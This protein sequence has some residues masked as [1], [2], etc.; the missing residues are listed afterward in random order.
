MGG[1]IMRK[2]KKLSTLASILI[3]ASFILP[4]YAIISSLTAAAPTS[5]SFGSAGGAPG[6]TITVTV[7]AN[8]LLT[9][10]GYNITFTYD[11]TVLT[12]N[13]TGTVN[14]EVAGTFV[15][16]VGTA[17]TVALALAGTEGSTKDAP[18][19]L[20][21]VAFTVLQTA[22]KNSALTL[23]VV[24]LKDQD[25]ATIPGVAKTNGT[26]QLS[27]IPT[28]AITMT[29]NPTSIVADGTA[30]TTITS[31]AIKDAGGA[32]VPDGT[33]V[34]VAT[35]QGT[36]VATDADSVTAGTQVATTAGV[37]TFGLTSNLVVGSATVTANTVAGDATGTLQVPFTAVQA[38]KLEVTQITNPV[39]AGT[40]SNVQVKAVNAAGVTA[41]GYTGTVHFTST[42]ANATL[43]ANYT[44]LAGDNGVKV[45]TGGV[46]LKTKGTQN[47]T[48][49][50]TTTAT[51]TGSQT[52]IV[53]NAGAAAK[54]NLTV[55]PATLMVSSVISEATLTATILD[56]NN[57]VVTSFTD[58]VTF[59]VMGATAAFG[60][61]KATFTS[62]NA[63]AGVATSY[64]QSA[65][66]LTGGTIAC[67][68][69]ATGLTQGTV[70]VITI[71]RTLVSIAISIVTGGKV[72]T[73]TPKVGE[74][75]QF[76]AIGTYD[77]TT[78][79]DI[80]ATV[81][82]ASSDLTK[83]DF[84]A[85][86]GRFFAKAVGATNVTATK[87]GKTST[88]VAM[89]VQAATA[90][91][92]NTT[93]LPTQTTFGGTV[94]LGAAGVVA[95][96]TGDGFNYTI[97][98]GPTGGT[99]SAA[100]LFTAGANAGVYVLKVEDKSS[101]A[102]ATY[103]VVVPIT[104]TPSSK[105]I[106]RNVPQAFIVNGAGT[107]YTWDVLDSMTSTTP[108]TTYGAW[109]KPNPVTDDNTNTFTPLATLAQV[110]TFYVQVT[111]AGDADLTA[112]NGLNKK[113]FG[114]FRIIPVA[115][116]TVNVKKSDGTALSGALVKVNYT[117][118]GS[119]T[120]G[121]DGKAVFT[122]LPDTGG[123]YIYDVSMAAY[124]PQ[125]VSSAEKTVNVTLPASAAT[126]TGTVQDSLAAPLVGAT[127][128]AYIPATPTTQ[129]EATTIAG[130]AY[131]INLPT[132]AATSGWTVVAGMATYTS[133]KQ[134]GIALAAGTATVN[135]TGANGLVL[136]GAG[137]ADAD[138]GGS[139]PK[140]D[141]QAGQTAASVE[142]PVGGVA[143]NSYVFIVPTAKSST[144]SSFTAAS[145]A[146]VYN[147]K[148]TS[149]AAGNTSLAAADIKRVIIALPLDLSVV[150]PGDMEK[151]V[152]V[153][154]TAA[155]E[156]LL[157]AGSVTT[158]PVANIMTTDYIGNGQFGTVTFWVDHLSFFGIGGGSGAG[159]GGEVSTSSGCFIATAAYGSYFDQHVRILR[160]FRDAYLITNDWG[161][162][163]VGFY[164]RHSPALANFIAKHDGIRAMVR[165]G[166]APVV[167]AAYVAI[168]TTPAE[169]VL[170]LLLLIGILTAGMVMIL[171]MRKFRRVIG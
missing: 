61:I 90:V 28:G 170:I 153:I 77:D 59:A 118:K 104:L 30:A 92:I 29:A 157:E 168:Y 87:S 103:T 17:G 76:K 169:K 47:V 5:V 66:S 143:A 126:I 105:N 165:L 164:Y 93:N 50:D 154:Y 79:E 120:T 24:S 124:V 23:T 60:N 141:T 158:V 51:I 20:A 97:V 36:I 122:N 25:G 125:T 140:T 112:A 35:N 121:A 119:V 88:A 46:T 34:T 49:T 42:D 78:T 159:G 80:T 108:V 155:T 132:G 41:T 107:T 94:N 98:S 18:G 58:P 48:A 84:S 116:Y 69:D 40:A 64:V 96:G 39:A 45:F 95:G 57:N 33:K 27:G 163:F 11:P 150:K 81:T 123:K 56:A 146:V 149:D 138:A 82:W 135:F 144:T 22:N 52:G 109:A 152:F 128:T 145:K 9:V 101:L 53:V 7:N 167:G 21:T 156:A 73:A 161:R 91:T 136:A 134:T 111:V 129:Y 110:T 19:V 38:T 71:P 32:N 83:G 72:T 12:A 106:L 55:Q 139:V 115:D 133:V 37:I 89:T 142:V 3:M 70:N 26:F 166:L 100:G 151:G 127:V 31:A 171:R 147:V 43:P 62:V 10:A 160:S 99:I 102:S 75:A 67:T 54:I 16:N 74:T 117:D 6:A 113:T 13:S 8:S 2:T 131:T 114:P 130:G 85:G 4:T 86:V 1:E 15:K 162:A 65:I 148:V 14:G 63:V 68:A 137:A 44:F